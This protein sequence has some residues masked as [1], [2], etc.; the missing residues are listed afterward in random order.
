MMSIDNMKSVQGFDQ[1]QYN[2]LLKEAQQH[3]VLQN[4]LEANLLAK[5]NEGKSFSEALKS[6]SLSLPN[7]PPA[8]MTEPLSYA[9]T[10][11]LPSFGA[12]YMA[13]IT[14]TSAE[15]R[16][17]AGEQRDLQT[18]VIA[19]KINQQ[20]KE[21]RKKAVTQLV[22]GVTTGSLQVALSA[23]TM[24]KQ[25]AKLNSANKI[26]DIAERNAATTKINTD[27]Q[28]VNQINQG[29]GSTLSSINQF[30]G[31]MFDANIKEM[32]ADI[33]RS[34]TMLDKLKNLDESLR[35][36][37]Q[38]TLGA[39]DSIQQSKNQTNTKILA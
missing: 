3:N 29:V 22:I 9:A 4:K 18:E 17:Q 32:D 10:A 37:I 35:E 15:Q 14:E 2:T 26:G 7:L 11:A 39:M 21:M 23:A 13:L 6:V 19:E 27:A 28:T 31:T 1:T 16:R 25:S 20:A 8:V 12:S 5:I 38:K 34:R 30:A 24:V 33:E 36:V